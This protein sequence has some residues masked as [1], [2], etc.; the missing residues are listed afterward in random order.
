MSQNYELDERE[1]NI[2]GPLDGFHDVIDE[3]VVPVPITT[4]SREPISRVPDS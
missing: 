4:M 3:V 2:L 1:S